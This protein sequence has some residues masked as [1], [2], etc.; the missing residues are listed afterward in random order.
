M[1]MAVTMMP[2]AGPTPSKP[3]TLIISAG[4]E[5][6]T[7]RFAVMASNCMSCNKPDDDGQELI[8][9]P[10]DY[11]FC[12]IPGGLKNGDGQIRKPRNNS[13]DFPSSIEKNLPISTAENQTTSQQKSTGNDDQFCNVPNPT[14][15]AYV[16]QSGICPT[17]D[18]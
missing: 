4:M 12:K 6:Q 9:G 1:A 14:W 13:R 16:L 17:I 10:A 18:A 3:K 8:K 2:Q 11:V 15:G 5:D 7:P